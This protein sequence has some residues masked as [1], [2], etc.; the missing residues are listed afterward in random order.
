MKWS[1]PT[2]EYKGAILAI[3]SALKEHCSFGFCGLEISAAVREAN[4]L[5]PGA[6][7][8]LGRITSNRDLP[9]LIL[10]FALA[11]FPAGLPRF[12]ESRSAYCIS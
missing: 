1:R 8:S 4:V 5:Q 9:R 3:M 6:M 10:F 12:I 7:G 11:I 2:F